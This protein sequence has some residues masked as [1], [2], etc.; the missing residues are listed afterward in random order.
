MDLGNPALP[1]AISENLKRPMISYKDMIV[2]ALRRSPEKR[3][4]LQE[5]YQVI[6]LLHPYYRSVADS[7]G[8]QNSIRHNL[9][10]HDCF[11]K[12]EIV[13]S[14]TNHVHYWTLDEE[15]LASG[16]GVKRK[17]RSKRMAP[18]NEDPAP[19]LGIHPQLALPSPVLPNTG[20]E[21][22]TPTLIG[23]DN[24]LQLAPVTAAPSAANIAPPVVPAA[25]LP[26]NNPNMIQD[27]L[28]AVRE[29]PQL[30]S[31][32]LIQLLR[33]VQHDQVHPN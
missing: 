14:K 16:V 2:D 4:K 29:N 30:V 8:W 25:D 26:L 33:G 13:G 17:S 11:V 1:E 20:S 12:E 3:L 9:S 28:N 24:D 5:I 21:E 19:S 31:A 22:E 18:R 27:L 23:I 10:L 6:R 15:K 32:I 7:W